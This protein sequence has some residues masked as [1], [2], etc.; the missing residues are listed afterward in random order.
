MASI[1]ATS[2]ITPISQLF[3]YHIFGLPRDLN[4]WQDKPSSY[5]LEIRGCLSKENRFTL[6]HIKELFEPVQTVVVLQCMTNVHWGR[7]QV[8]GARLWDVLKRAGIDNNALKVAFKGGEGF[9]T[10]LFAE[11]IKHDPDRYL[12][13]YEMNRQPLTPQHGFPLRIV[14]EGKYAYK[15][16]KWLTAIE[17]MDYDYKGHYEGKRGWSDQALRGKPV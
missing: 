4:K 13:A 7:V 14:A 9:S 5:Y 2:G 15:W 6:A 12:L 3:T 1:E 16:C 17:V 10:D 8:K 11:E